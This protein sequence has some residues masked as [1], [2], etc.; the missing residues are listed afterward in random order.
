MGKRKS[1][2][3]RFKPYEHENEIITVEHEHSVTGVESGERINLS[4][5]DHT[6]KH[7]H[8]RF[9]EVRSYSF[10]KWKVKLIRRDQ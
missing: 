5:Y 4:Q 9:L 1:S 2:Q 10:L 7:I 3:Y 6:T 8:Y